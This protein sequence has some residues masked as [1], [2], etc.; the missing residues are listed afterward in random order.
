VAEAE[1]LVTEQLL[2][3]VQAAVAQ[4]LLLQDHLALPADL[5]TQAAVAAVLECNS[6]A[7]EL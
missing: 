7:L 1:L 2:P 3:V 4:V 5:P 6:V